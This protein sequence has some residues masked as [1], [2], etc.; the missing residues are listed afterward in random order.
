MVLAA[1]L[2][3]GT[4]FPM[5][6]IGLKAG[7]APIGFVLLRFL[8]AAAVLTAICLAMGRFRAEL[9]RDKWIWWL[10]L[11][12]ATGYV[13]QF[14]GQAS[15]TASKAALLVNINVLFTALLAGVFLGE[16]VGRGVWAACG[17]GVLGL[18]LLTTNGDP[19]V[20]LGPSTELRGDVLTFMTGVSWTF[21]ILIAK[22]YMT[23]N[24]GLDI[25]AFT[26]ATFLVSLPFLA[27]A[28]LLVEGWSAP[29]GGPAW[30][31]ILYL[32]L[33]PT[34][35]AHLLWQGGLQRVTANSSALLLLLEVVVAVA[36]SVPLL[37]ERMGTVSAVG[38][39]LIL[40]AILIAGHAA[41][42]GPSEAPPATASP[43]GDPRR[44]P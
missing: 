15:T 22:A 35:V 42:T 36:I 32:A 27:G 38:A 37:G 24:P 31:A 2:L 33:L 26:T 17:I 6:E 29:H 43:A 25:L 18:F 20:V 12:N 41:S 7:L 4:S 19:R 40:V 44:S 39:L 3:W 28:A 11:V 23:R 34:I 5:V 21:Y 14:A 30:F 8:I 10:C 16:R 1:A 13:A 9:L